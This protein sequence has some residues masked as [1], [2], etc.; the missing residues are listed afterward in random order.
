MML[1]LFVNWLNPHCWQYRPCSDLL[2]RVT[3]VAGECWYWSVKWLPKCHSLASRSL[4]T[5][6]DACLSHLCNWMKPTIPKAIVCHCYCYYLNYLVKQNHLRWL[7]FHLSC[8]W[9]LFERWRRL[10]TALTVIVRGVQCRF[11]VFRLSKR[12]PTRSPWLTF[13]ISL[14]KLNVSHL[15]LSVIQNI[16]FTFKN[17]CTYLLFCG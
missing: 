3:H 9:G 7:K 8:P 10:R 1:R 6:L 5:S 16:Y 15:F 17:V 2:V 12:K 14:G 4:W 13:G 11:V